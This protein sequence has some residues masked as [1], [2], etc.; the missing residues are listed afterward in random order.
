MK[1][2]DKSK[3]ELIAELR[4]LRANVAWLEN[5]EVEYAQ[6]MKEL[7]KSQERFSKIFQCSPDILLIT[8]LH[9]GTIVDCNQSF[10]RAM[11][12]TRGEVLGK[13][14]RQLNNWADPKDRETFVAMLRD[15]G[16]CI[17]FETA[18]RNKA[19]GLL[20]VLIS[21]R[22]LEIEDEQL[23]LSVTG[24][25]SQLKSAEESIR[26]SE[27]KFRLLFETS[28]DAICFTT[29]D[30][31]LTDVNQAAVELFGYSKEELLGSLNVGDLYPNPDQRLKF[32]DAIER[33]GFVRDFEITMHD[34]HGK[35]LPCLL[36]STLRRAADGTVLGYQGIIRD[37]TRQKQAEA[38]LLEAAEKYRGI[39]QDQTD[40]ICRFLPDGTLTFVNDAYCRYFK[41]A[42]EE[43]VGHTFLSFIPEEDRGLIGEHLSQ[44][45]PEL[46][47]ATHE[48]RVLG[49]DGEVRW[50]QWTNRMIVDEE[51]RPIEFQSVGRDVTERKDMEEALRRSSEK[52]K[53]FAYSVSHDLKSPAV[54]VYGLARLLHQHYGDA[55]DERG[56]K[57][58]DQIKA[59]AQQI[60]L[61]AERISHYIT[62]KETPLAI[63][64]VNLREILDTVREEFSLRFQ[65]RGI[66]WTEPQS[67]PQLRAD[68]LCLVRILRN[69]VDNALKYGGDKLSRI[70]VGYAESERFHEVSV[71]DDGVGLR[72][73][74]P[75]KIFQLFQRHESSKGIAGAG[76]GLAI[77]REM[78]ERHGGKAW[79][80]PG[81]ETGTTFFVSFS[82]QL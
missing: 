70:T 44:L 52:I 55:L 50:Q 61:L 22:V 54:A 64:T 40:L 18:F 38:A 65:V 62:S 11:G 51:Q 42:P 67:N 19:G 21:A 45:T 59:A 10:L 56:G 74:D 28:R 5:L 46:P 12:Y 76:L 80:A 66:T 39:V 34:K 49:P 3:E 63:E 6:A 58:C 73:Q 33:H 60:A 69:L 23:V 53:L 27:E 30:G 43:L 68:R 82:K 57:L 79:S 1:D 37:I 2:Q 26:E 15:K 81:Q 32:I 4:E 72:G 25:I 9:D 78:A 31:R 35:V 41:K 14:S 48:H 20:P 7:G 77:V 17:G 47:V 71:H 29:R 8:R 24:D 16:E 13:S 36:T 75:E